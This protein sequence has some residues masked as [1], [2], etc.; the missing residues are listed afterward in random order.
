MLIGPAYLLPPSSH[1]SPAEWQPAPRKRPQGNSGFQ[2]FHDFVNTNQWTAAE[3][4]LWGLSALDGSTR[5]VGQAFMELPPATRD[6]LAQNLT[7]GTLGFLGDAL[8]EYARTQDLE[9][10]FELRAENIKIA[11]ALAQIPDKAPSISHPAVTGLKTALKSIHQSLIN[12]AA[13][14]W[15]TDEH[16][17]PGAVCTA[18]RSSA[19]TCRS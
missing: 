19:R 1:Q 17:V 5:R 9:R 6:H 14:V 7:P 15:A 13:D 8:T 12:E 2:A 3:N 11:G 10:L 16:G 4:W 18:S